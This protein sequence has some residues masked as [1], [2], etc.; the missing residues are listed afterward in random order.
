MKQ[1]AL[2]AEFIGTF[3]FVFISVG[4]IVADQMMAG[5][6][7]PLAVVLASGIALAVLMSATAAHSGGH[8]NPAITFGLLL[9]GKIETRTAVSYIVIQCLGALVA[10][11]ILQF[12]MPTLALAAV[13]FGTPRLGLNISSSQ[14]VLMEFILAFILMF[15][16][17]GTMIDQRGPKTGG[18]FAGL[19]TSA[20]L[21]VAGPISGGTFNPARHFGPA[22]ISRTVDNFWIYWI[23]PLAGAALASL[24]YFHI[25]ERQ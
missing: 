10:M 20:G 13:W 16:F 4:T 18:L 5:R 8:L 2:V 14:A 9:A 3:A 1:K 25:L 21:F 15:V 17:C 24:L 19:A 11:L 6:L 23:G 22:L 12:A 7:G